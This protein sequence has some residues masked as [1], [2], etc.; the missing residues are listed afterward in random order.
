MAPFMSNDTGTQLTNR[1]R[2]PLLT[3]FLICA[4]FALNGVFH[5]PVQAA[6]GKVDGIY[7]ESRGKGDTLVLIHGGQMDGRMWNGQFQ[8]WS[9]SYRVIRCDIR[10]FGRS[11][12]P[13]RPYSYREDLFQLFQRLRVSHATIIGLSLGGAIATDFTLTHPEAVDGLVLVCPGLGGFRF[14]DPANNLRPIVDAAREDN[15]DRVADL[16]LANPYMSVAMENPALRESLRRISR[17]NARA[18]LNNPLLLRP[19]QPP[20][21]ER[22]GEIRTPCLIIGGERDVSDVQAIVNKLG[23]EIP[24]ARKHI[25]PGAGHIVPME[26]PE[27]FNRLVMEFLA[28]GARKRNQR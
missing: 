8:L 4:A 18:W 14:S 6:S 7:Y 11:D 25:I 12:P 22:L 19:M 3:A 1:K 13:A 10:G 23:S 16:W 9:R 20:A 2:Q 26:K 21:A 28:E 5:G 15:P 17:D 24:G 27:E